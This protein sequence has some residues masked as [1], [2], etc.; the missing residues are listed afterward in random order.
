MHLRG[1]VS[2]PAEQ[3][4]NARPVRQVEPTAEESLAALAS[5]RGWH[6]QSRSGGELSCLV[7]RSMDGEKESK[8]SSSSIAQTPRYTALWMETVGT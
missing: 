3:S 6:A 8:H 2:E 7:H 5:S 4:A 1:L